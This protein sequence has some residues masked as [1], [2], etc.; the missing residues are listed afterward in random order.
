MTDFSSKKINSYGHVDGCGILLLGKKSGIFLILLRYWNGIYYIPKG[1]RKINENICD[2]SMRELE[3]YTNVKRKEY[4]IL[5]EPLVIDYPTILQYIM[6]SWIYTIK[7]CM[8]IWVWS[9]R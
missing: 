3:R 9:I 6:V 2:G 4:H 5:R 8:Y 7:H 1:H